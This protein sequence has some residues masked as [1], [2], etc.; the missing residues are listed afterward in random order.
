MLRAVS[1]VQTQ[2]GASRRSGLQVV[3]RTADVLR[4]LKDHPQGLTLAELSG[5]VALPKSSV[6]RLV[7]A[8]QQEGLLAGG[9]RGRI[10]LG[11]L[12]VQLAGASERSLGEELLAAMRRLSAD[13]HETVDL[14]VLDGDCIRFVAQQPGQRRLRAVS[15]VGARFPVHSCASGKALLAHLPRDEVAGLLP[16]RLPAL[17]PNTITTRKR[18]FDELDRIREAGVAFDR[19]E[20]SEGI[21][22]VGAVLAD[23]WGSIAGISVPVP[24][25]RFVGHEQELAEHLLAICEPVLAAPARH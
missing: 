18:L 6:H 13:L 8:L 21:S 25:Q 1:D 12:L 24:T 5:S 3:N 20:H 22:A 16:A 2:P 7:A 15:A 4:A 17:T 14:S 11:P 10:R 23:A 9:S 19:Q